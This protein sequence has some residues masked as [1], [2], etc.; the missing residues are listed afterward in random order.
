MLINPKRFRLKNALHRSHKAGVTRPP[1]HLGRIVV[2][3]RIERSLTGRKPVVLTDR[4]RD[5]VCCF[6][7][8]RTREQI[9]VITHLH[10]QH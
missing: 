7:G 9:N 4:R 5:Q 6:Q 2:S 10:A 3:E 8:S 1:N